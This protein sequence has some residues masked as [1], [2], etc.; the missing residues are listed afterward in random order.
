MRWLIKSA[1][2][3][4]SSHRSSF[5]LTFPILLKSLWLYA[6]QYS[7]LCP[8]TSPPD[9]FFFLLLFYFLN[10]QFSLHFNLLFPVSHLHPKFLFLIGGRYKDQLLL[11]TCEEWTNKLHA[12]PVLPSLIA[13]GFWLL[14]NKKVPKPLGLLWPTPMNNVWWQI[15]TNVCFWHLIYCTCLW[16]CVCFFSSVCVCVCVSD[17]NHNFFLILKWFKCSIFCQARSKFLLSYSAS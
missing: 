6:V 10:V 2:L 13:S 11:G 14:E 12:A 5:S 4:C 7:Q 8:A 17:I 15:V 9:M 16:V 3:L 1:K